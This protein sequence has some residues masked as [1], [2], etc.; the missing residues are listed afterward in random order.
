MSAVQYL[1]DLSIMPA[2]D[3]EAENLAQLA[4]AGYVPDT[5]RASVAG[6]LVRLASKLDSDSVR[7]P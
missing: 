4:D 7:L 1:V 5:I 2:L 3:L 6:G